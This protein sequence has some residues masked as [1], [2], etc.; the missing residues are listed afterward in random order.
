M[1]ALSLLLPVAGFAILWAAGLG[2]ADL[3]APRM[4]RDARAALAAP[5]AA[6][7]V[8]CASPL[9][10]LH[11]TP[12]ILAGA[13]LVCLGTLTVARRRSAVA[14]ARNARWPLAV[15]A[16]ALVLSAAPALRNGSW[17]ATSFG[18]ADP[19][20]WT[21]QAKSLADGPPSSPAASYPDRVSYELLTRDH[22]PV[23]LP[24]GLG[25]VADLGR[26][27]PAKAYE[28][29]A[30]MISALLALSVYVGARGCLLWSSRLSTSAGAVVG[31]N[32]LMLLSTYYG[33]QAQLLL[34]AFGTLAVL[35][36][37]VSMDRKARAHEAL[38]PAVFLAAGISTYG[39]VFAT[40]IG[41][42]SAAALACWI[43]NPRSSVGRRRIARRLGIVAGGTLVL[44]LFEI[45][46]ALEAFGQ[47]GG[48]FDPVTLR[49]LAR[50]DWAFPSDAIGLTNTLGLI[51]HGHKTPGSGWTVF[52]LVL[53]LPLLIAGA[54]QVRHIRNPSSYVLVAAAAS[55]LGL[56]AVL[57]IANVSPYASLKLMA[58]GAPIFTLLAL[59]AF[60][61][62]GNDANPGRKVKTG[63]T[64]N[65]RHIVRVLFVTAAVTT[66]AGVSLVTVAL[67]VMGNRPATVVDGI[68]AATVENVPRS[69]TIRI[70]VTNVWRQEW[71]V[72]F[73]RDRRLSV[74]RPSA[75]LTGFSVPEGSTRRRFAAPASYGIGPTQ[76]G[77]AVWRGSGVVIYRL[78][79]K[80][81]AAATGS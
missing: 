4:P 51:A 49:S 53:S 30:A 32:G 27:D 39:W 6:A 29:F 23:A 9:A 56:L 76:A 33:W 50:Y 19:Y 63:H 72:Y 40:F 77:S 25:A 20:V 75:Y 35:T 36:I 80:E 68:V 46:Q 37:P 73:L 57:A 78:R 11:V 13:V 22:W 59:S 31:A 48:R 41:I 38:L 15:A 79:S 66:F 62:G 7:A 55:L 70:D 65:L 18:N 58:Y 21:S 26:L 2:A 52:A 24:V 69:E 3:L 54:M 45:V 10:L 64:A 42:A 1:G 12:G 17:V 16:F 60:Q 44:G 71:L 34:T 81:L 8:V 67:G 28:A 43:V 14:V 5:L 61:S 74:S 47:T